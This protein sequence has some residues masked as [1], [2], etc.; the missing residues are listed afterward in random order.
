MAGWFVEVAAFI[1]C[2]GVFLVCGDFAA[3]RYLK[4]VA[5][6]E[7]DGV[8][9]TY[10]MSPLFGLTFFSLWI[11]GLPQLIVYV[12]MTFME[13]EMNIYYVILVL[14]V[15]YAW[16]NYRYFGHWIRLLGA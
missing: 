16:T 9:F 4:Y 5:K 11:Y 7:N 15:T 3:S 12:Y 8:R 10:Y 14:I 13:R 2:F 1:V 6:L